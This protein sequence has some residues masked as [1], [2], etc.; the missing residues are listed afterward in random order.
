MIESGQFILGDSSDVLFSTQ[1]CWTLTKRW[2]SYYST[3]RPKIKSSNVYISNTS[4]TFTQEIDGYVPEWIS[5]ALLISLSESKYLSVV[6]DFYRTSSSSSAAVWKYESPTLYVNLGG[7]YDVRAHIP[8]RYLEIKS[9]YGVLTDVDLIDVN[10][11]D[12]LFIKMMTSNIMIAIGRS[13]RA[14]TQS[15]FPIQNDSSDLVNEGTTMMQEVTQELQETSY[16]HLGAG[17]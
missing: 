8:L 14:F 4:Y 9:E 16:W 3:Y 13:R 17:I 11:S 2:M 6:P 15:D 10:D 12:Y 1:R 7:M 5:A